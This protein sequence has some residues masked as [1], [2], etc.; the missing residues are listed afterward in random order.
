MKKRIITGFMAAAMILTICPISASAATVK[1]LKEKDGEIE[2]A[3]LGKDG[4]MVIQGCP[5]DKDS[6]Y[7]YISGSKVKQLDADED[8]GEIESFVDRTK[9]ETDNDYS[10]AVATG[11][12]T[13]S[14]L[15]LESLFYKKTKNSDVYDF[16][17]K[18]DV[19]FDTI[20]RIDNTSTWFYKISDRF[21]IINES[22]TYMDISKY[23]NLQV[24]LADRDNTIS[25]KEFGKTYDTDVVAELTDCTP[26]AQDKSYLYFLCTVKVQEGSST[27]TDVKAVMKVSRTIKSNDDTNYVSA[28]NSYIVDDSDIINATAFTA[29]NGKL[30]ALTMNEDDEK[31]TIATTKAERKKVDNKYV[32]YLSVDDTEK[33]SATNYVTDVYGNIWLIDS[34]KIYGFDGE[35]LVQ[36]FKCDSSANNLVVY[37]A[38]N[39]VAW[40]DGSDVYYT[41][42]G[43]STNS[44]K[45]KDDDD[46]DDDDN[47]NSDTAIDMGNNSQDNSDLTGVDQNGNSTLTGPDGTTN[48]GTNGNLVTGWNKAADGTYTYSKDGTT[49]VK[50]DWIQDGSDWYYLGIDGVMKTGWF[51]DAKTWAIFHADEYTGKMTTGWYKDYRNNEWYLLGSNGA[52]QVGWAKDGSDWYYLCTTGAMMQGWMQDKEGRYF[53]LGED[54]RM[55]H[56][57]YV[58]SYKLGSDGAWV[59]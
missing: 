26:I 35:D 33:H 34:G 31:L 53:Y 29:R 17:S 11:K 6:G 15:D 36:Y 49:T 3:C 40:E 43:T 16:A 4:K 38:S 39:V 57:C 41:V 25:I 56:D 19:E 8:L 18:S 27:S 32:S 59:K 54:G 51:R 30:Y 47:S 44:D 10:I 20:E 55:R 7:W 22:G 58:G 45:D 1:S 13:D 46:D 12:V 37:D 50:S 21:G 28:V 24:K 23:A 48:P 42:T 9:I 5:K 2:T 52:M 14:D